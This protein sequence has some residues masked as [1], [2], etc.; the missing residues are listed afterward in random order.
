MQT[1]WKVELSPNAAK[2]LEKLPVKIVTL[3]K[4]LEDDLRH[5][6]PV[7]RGWDVVRLKG[8]QEWRIKLTR[9][10]RV[11]IVVETPRIIVVKVMHRRDVYR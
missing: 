5:E 6:G 11:L 3:Y 8:L 9:E 2:Q 4:G 1:Q 10:Y 7:P